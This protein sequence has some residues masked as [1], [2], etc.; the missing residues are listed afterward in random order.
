[1]KQFERPY[2]G[3]AL[4]NS[5]RMLKWY[6]V[7]TSI[8]FAAYAHAGGVTEIGSP[9]KSG[10]AQ[11]CKMATHSAGATNLI[12]VISMLSERK[13]IPDK[14]LE[15]LA[16]ALRG[17]SPLAIAKTD[18]AE[19]LLPKARVD[20]DP[21][22][23][24]Y[25]RGLEIGFSSVSEIDLNRLADWLEVLTEQKAKVERERQDASEYTAFPA[26]NYLV[27]KM[28]YDME[29]EYGSPERI[30]NFLSVFLSNEASL[31]AR[32]ESLTS[33]LRHRIF[34]DSDTKDAVEDLEAQGV[35]SE[36]A[37]FNL[38]SRIF[39]AS[40]ERSQ[41]AIAT[42]L[43]EGQTNSL[44]LS[45]K[46]LKFIRRFF[47]E[48]KS[49]PQA[50]F[51]RSVIFILSNDSPEKS[52]I[53]NDFLNIFADD[54]VF[55]REFIER[56]PKFD[57]KDKREFKGLNRN[58]WAYSFLLIEDVIF[59]YLK[60]ATPAQVDEY[61]EEA[62]KHPASAHQDWTQSFPAMSRALEAR[63]EDWFI[64][65][66]TD[67]Y[68]APRS[69][70]DS[71]AIS[72][73][74]YSYDTLHAMLRTAIRVSTEPARVVSIAK[75]LMF[76]PST[77]VEEISAIAA[78]SEPEMLQAL[79]K[80]GFF[81]FYQVF[82]IPGLIDSVIARASGPE[83]VSFV[84]GSM[85]K[86]ALDNTFFDSVAGAREAAFAA[87]FRKAAQAQN[88]RYMLEHIPNP[89]EYR[90]LQKAGLIRSNMRQW[91]ESWLP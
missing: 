78:K 62:V 18:F 65:K 46:R 52:Q 41:S 48:A 19:I 6:V 11:R 84:L 51:L 47:D 24:L 15:G 66:I 61:L 75:M 57:F 37:K 44:E 64:G 71:Y 34:T 4:A 23:A 13:M 86:S 81:N 88:V 14:A 20:S 68:F 70:S 35:F 28:R 90:F 59:S 76:Y 27:E 26:V 2:P 72:K 21:A 25:R 31:D 49:L 83:L 63:P 79:A 40:D 58:W 45:S 5:L 22:V 42:S 29:E 16:K 73:I 7:L 17:R 12:A 82:A 69:G 33:Y 67:F 89:G 56:V 50:Y 9:V 3:P 39:L 36:G 10:R 77:S 8:L 53:R 60:S 87:A 38:M 55:L 85:E 80:G 43:M 32:R 74:E 91:L 1:M 30:T 54:P